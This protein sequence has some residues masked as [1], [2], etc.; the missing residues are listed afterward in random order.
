MQLRTLDDDVSRKPVLTHKPLDVQSASQDDDCKTDSFVL[1]EKN[2]NF[3]YIS[4]T[5]NRA[6]VPA[7]SRSETPLNLFLKAEN[8]MAPWV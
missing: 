8:R 3:C 6:P 2:G 7:Y 4:T 5:N 1:M